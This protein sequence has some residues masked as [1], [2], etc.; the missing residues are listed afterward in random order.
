MP[1]NLAVFS[2]NK[3]DEVITDFPEIEE[4]YIA[5]HSLGGAS[6]IIK[7]INLENND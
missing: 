3:A 6:E 2:P 7:F 4:W 1:L 5:G